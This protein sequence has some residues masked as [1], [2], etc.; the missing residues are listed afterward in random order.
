MILIRLLL[1]EI[2]YSRETRRDTW[3]PHAAV[4]ALPRGVGVHMQYPVSAQQLSFDAIFIPLLLPAFNSLDD[5]EFD[6]YHTVFDDTENSM[7]SSISD[8]TGNDLL[9]Q[10]KVLDPSGDSN[11]THDAEE[12]EEDFNLLAFN[13]NLSIAQDIPVNNVLN[14]AEIFNVERL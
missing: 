9:T 2:V 12:R 8:I 3:L 7:S 6:P 10:G 5:K 1:I 4:N 13:Q 14:N 11:S